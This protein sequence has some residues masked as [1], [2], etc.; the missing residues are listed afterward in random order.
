M[1]SRQLSINMGEVHDVCKVMCCPGQQEVVETYF[2]SV[3][4]VMP[5]LWQM[6]L[7]I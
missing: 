5:R 3:C 7:Q 4:N 1:V 6:K 2:D